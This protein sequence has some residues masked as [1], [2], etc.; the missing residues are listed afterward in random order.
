MYGK[1]ANTAKSKRLDKKLLQRICKEID[2]PLNHT[3]KLSLHH[4]AK[5]GCQPDGGFFD[6]NGKM[7]AAFEAKTQ[8]NKGNAIERWWKNYCIIKHFHPEC[9]YITL[10]AG[11]GCIKDG[12]IYANFALALHLEDK[13]NDSF[14][15]LHNTGVS[16]YISQYGFFEEDIK[17]IVENAIQ[18]KNVS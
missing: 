1:Y 16:F 12:P 18:A 6:N 4:I 9:K 5:L 11:D 7:I 13:P 8:G 14:N 3:S 2:T 15:Q 10:A 17:E